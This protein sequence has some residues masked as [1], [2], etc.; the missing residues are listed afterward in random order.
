MLQIFAIKYVIES[1]FEKLASALIFFIIN[2][3]GKPNH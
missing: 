1:S 3:N 2:N